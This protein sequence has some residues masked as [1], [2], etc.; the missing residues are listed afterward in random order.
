MVIESIY[1]LCKYTVNTVCGFGFLQS[2]FFFR[3]LRRRR[4]HE[5]DYE[6]S[7]VLLEYHAVLDRLLLVKI[8]PGT[9]CA[10]FS[11]ASVLQYPVTVLVFDCC[12]HLRNKLIVYSD[13]AVW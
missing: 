7:L 1:Y 9:V 13:V 12:L 5:V 8:I 2:S 11:V 4:S 10:L 6:E 3:I